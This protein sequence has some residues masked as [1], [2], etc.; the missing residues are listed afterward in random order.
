MNAITRIEAGTPRARSAAIA[1]ASA[2]P[3]SNSQKDEV[4][5]VLRGLGTRTSFPR[6]T[7]I[8]KEHGH[9]SAVYRVMSGAVALWRTRTNGR[10]HIVDFRLPGEF[11]GVVHR[12]EYTITAEAA[13][14]TVVFAYRRGQV[15]EICDAVPSV[16]RALTALL[17]EPSLSRRDALNAERQTAKE[18]IVEFLRVAS[19]RAGQSDEVRLPVSD[20]DIADYFDLPRAVVAR[21]LHELA[22]AGAIALTQT[23]DIVIRDENRLNAYA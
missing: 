18:R 1:A 10:R 8:F 4:V 5:M 2:K 11:F 22:I 15:D 20:G 21:G 19:E 14:D 23:G 7:V 17:A 13:A 9:A 6:G 16:R 3:V 12:P